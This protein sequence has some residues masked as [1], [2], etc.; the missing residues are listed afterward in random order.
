MLERAQGNLGAARYFLK[1]GRPEAFLV[2][3][4]HGRLDNPLLSRIAAFFLGST[5]R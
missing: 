3:Q 4:S 2:Q 1:I 5:R